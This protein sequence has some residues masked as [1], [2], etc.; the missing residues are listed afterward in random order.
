MVPREEKN[1]PN[2]RIHDCFFFTL[3]ARTAQLHESDQNDQDEIED[4]QYKCH[5]GNYLLRSSLLGIC[6]Q[7][8]SAAAGERTGDTV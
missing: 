2:T 8:Q 1:S 4:S 6:E 3:Y 7:I 5:I